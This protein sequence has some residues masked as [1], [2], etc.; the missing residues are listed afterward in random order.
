MAKGMEGGVKIIVGLGNPGPQYQQT[1]HNVGFR[2]LELL[3]ERLGVPF[4]REK[5]Q[6]QLAE[7]RYGQQR[8]ILVKPLTFMNN[9]GAAVAKIARNT[10]R[11]PEDLLVATDDVEL[12][13]GRVRF[14]PAGSSGG[15][16]GLKSVI[17]HLGTR[18][19]PRLR[20]GVGKEPEQGGLVGHVLGKFRPEEWPEVD[21]MLGRA[22]DGILRFLEDGVETAMNEFNCKPNPAS[23]R[24]AT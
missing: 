13:L 5:Y 17:A 6:A 16:N 19:F 10:L 2:A 15:H 18:D 12:P 8:L 7:C 9:S 3:A 22:V 24:E 20:M 4:D 14:R 11:G 23:N 21:A 1:R